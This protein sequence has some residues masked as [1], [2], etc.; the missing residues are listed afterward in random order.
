MFSI[1]LNKNR[2]RMN[3]VNSIGIVMKKRM[4][5]FL[6][7]I[8]M[9]TLG[10]S[11]TI[12]IN[13]QLFVGGTYHDSCN[14]TVPIDLNTVGSNG[15]GY[16]TATKSF[17]NNYFILVM[18]PA[19][20]AAM[21][22]TD[23][24]ASIAL[25]AGT[26]IGRYTFS[27]SQVPYT[28]F[29]NGV[30]PQ[31]GAGINA[32]NVVFKV[33]STLPFVVSDVTPVVARKRTAA[34]RLKSFAT[35]GAIGN[36][37]A[38][39]Y[40]PNHFAMFFGYCGAV[41]DSKGNP[42]DTSISLTDSTIGSI[43]QPGSYDSVI[44][45]NNS[46]HS[47]IN[48]DTVVYRAKL[49]ATKGIINFPSSILKAG[50]Y[51]TLLLKALDDSGYTSSK[52]YFILNTGWVLN[53]QKS[54]S[55][56]GC[57]GDTVNL[58]P[59]IN[60][61]QLGHQFGI[62]DNFPGLL[63]NVNWGDPKKPGTTNFSYS[64][65]MNNGGILSHVY[66]TTSCLNASKSWPITAKLTN[67]FQGNSCSYPVATPTIQIFA[68]VKAKFIHHQ[69]VCAFN[70]LDTAS[71]TLVDS[72]YAGSNTTCTGT[73][74]YTWYRTFVGCGT[75]ND[76][77]TNPFVAVDSS[78]TIISGNPVMQSVSHW[79]HKDVFSQP[80]KYIFELFADN[81]SCKTDG[82]IDS[83]MVVAPPKA[84]FLFDSLGNKVSSI[85][86]C[87]PLT[88]SVNNLSDSTCS[89]KWSFKWEVLDSLNG[90]VV[91]IPGAGSAYTF[92]GSSKNTDSAPSLVFNIQG[93]YKV[94]L[95]GSNA[96]TKADTAYRVVKVIGNGG[97]TFPTGNK[98]KIG[99][100][101]INAFCIYQGASKTVNFD[102]TVKT[103]AI[104]LVLKPTFGGT[105][106]TVTPFTWTI[107]DISGIHTYNG[108][109]SSSS[110]FPNV[111]F[112]PPANQDGAYLVKVEY[113]STC[114]VSRDS[115]MLYLNRQVIP[116]ITIPSKDTLVCPNTTSLNFTGTVT[117]ANGTNS[118]YSSTSWTDLSTNTIFANGLNA[119]LNSISTKTIKFMAYKTQPNG[120]PDTFV[121]RKI[122]LL[123][124][125]TGRD[126]GFRNC[127][128][129]QLNY[130]PA[131]TSTT[132]GNTFTW[133]S[134]VI[135]SAVVSGNTNCNGPCGNIKDILTGDGNQDVVIYTV[136]PISANGCPGNTFQVADTILPY[137]IITLK[138]ASFKD[139]ICSGAKTHLYVGSS[140]SGTI[141]NWS[142]TVFS[143]NNLTPV[144][145]WPS[146]T[147]Q[148]PTS[149]PGPYLDIAFTN[150]DNTLD[151]FKVVATVSIAGSCSSKPDSV[152]MYVIP[153][154]TQPKAN[155]P[156]DSI[157]LC[158]LSSVNLNAT[159]PP[160]SK[161]EIGIW[162]QTNGA[163]PVAAISN[164]SSPTATAF[165]APGNVYQLTWSI[166]SP[167]AATYGCP[168]LSDV[169][170][171]F[172]RP[173]VT[174]ANAGKDTTICSY[175]GNNVTINLNGNVDITRPWE[176]GTWTAS[177]TPPAVADNF[178]STGI[179]TSHKYND[180]YIFRGAT[181]EYDLV[182]TISND[183]GCPVSFDT[184]KI[185]AGFGNNTISKDTSICV[186]QSVAPLFNGSL[187]TGGGGS[188]V[189][190]WYSG[191]LIPGA[192]SQNY[193][194]IPSPA[195]TTT[196]YRT[197]SSVNCPTANLKSNFATITVYQLPK[198]GLIVTKKT[199]CGA[200]SSYQGFVLDS[201]I[202]RIDTVNYPIDTTCVYSWYVNGVLKYTGPFY[203]KSGLYTIANPGDS[204]IV[205]LRDSSKHGCGTVVSI[206]DTFYTRIKPQPLFSASTYASCNA[207][208]VTFT[209]T[210][211]NPALYAGWSWN[212]GDGA[213]PQ[214]STTANTYNPPGQI[215]YAASKIGRDSVYNICLSAWTACLDTVTLCK[216]VTIM[217]KPNPSFYMSKYSGCAP[218]Y[219]TL[220]NTTL[221][222][223]DSAR[224]YWYYPQT[225]SNYTT[226]YNSNPVP[227]VFPFSAGVML[228][229][230]NQCGEDS[231]KIVN[232]QVAYTAVNLKLGITPNHKYACAP[233]ISDV[234]Y[235]AVGADKVDFWYYPY[236][237]GT[238]NLIPDH[239]DYVTAGIYSINF[240][241]AG[242]YVVKVKASNI[243]DSVVKYDTVTMF[244]TP[245]PQFKLLKDTICVGDTVR[246]V[247]LTAT[248]GV[249]YYWKFSTQGI[250]L[251]NPPT[252]GIAN[253]WTVFTNP[254]SDSIALAATIS[255][256]F[257]SPGYCA[258]TTKLP[259]TVVTTQKANFAVSNTHPTC[260]PATVTFTNN[261]PSSATPPT[262]WYFN[263]PSLTPTVSGTNNTFYT[264]QDTGTY[265][266]VLNTMSAGGCKYTDTQ[267]IVVTS[268]YAQVWK[269]DHGFIC[270]ATPVKFQVMNPSGVDSIFVWHFG[271]G[272]TATTP[273][274]APNT[275]HSY[276]NCGNYFPTVDL[277]S[278]GGCKFT[279]N[280][281]TGDTIKVDYVKAD[282]TYAINKNC[283]NTNI[284]FT[285]ISSSCSGFNANSWSW[286][287]GDIGLP[288][289]FSTL[290]N[291]CHAYHTTDTDSILLQVTANS[292]CTNTTLVPI[293]IKVNSIPQ[294]TTHVINPYNGVVA[295][296]GQTVS[297]SGT[298][299][300]ID[301][302][303]D[304]VWTFG[305]FG[306]TA[307]GTKT[308]NTYAATGTYLDTFTV[309]TIFGCTA[310]FFGTVNVL[311]T[312]TI[313]IAQTNPP[314]ICRGQ[315]YP[316]NATT[317]DP[318]T[319][320][321]LW[322]PAP[323]VTCVNA[324]CS[325]VTVNPTTNSVLYVQGLASNG[326]TGYGDT[327]LLKVIQPITLTVSPSNDTICIG[328]SVQLH[329]VSIG[330]TAFVWDAK[331]SSLNFDSIPD[332]IA[333][334]KHIGMNVY[335]L[336]ASNT[337]FKD[338]VQVHIAVGGY[339]VISLGAPGY[340]TLT[341]QTGSTLPMFNYV[342][343]SN[344]TFKTFVWTPSTGL[345][346]NNC[347][348]PV[349]TVAGNELY[350]L[351][352]T[353]I[354]GCSDT[355]YL[356]IKT[357]CQNSQVYI[358]NAFTPDGDGRNDVLM[359]R[360]SGI[361]LVKNFR[362][363]NRWGQVVFERANFN[364]NDPQFGWDGKVRNTSTFSPPD[365]YVYYCEVVCDDD[366]PFTYQGNIT[367]IK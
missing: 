46:F 65:L 285:D 250:T 340:D 162:S 298:A 116:K 45:I 129:V 223:F 122:T 263:Y 363:Y 132:A 257:P 21:S 24:S 125:V 295:C 12:T 29:V 145:T 120:C 326:C 163:L 159:V 49:N 113:S 180:G 244:L 187:P 283:G 206:K 61:I 7:G 312:P 241:T 276:I 191:S 158:N 321:F 306:Q 262:V 219:D 157:Y 287:F 247:N 194:P 56:N 300:S 189:Y 27:G 212:F 47:L 182:W 139:T 58:Y 146:Q 282:F 352:A 355:D 165:V 334:P 246:P 204:A 325:N 127:S 97:V 225:P 134:S 109:T 235:N 62:Y 64:Q 349:V 78:A 361:K 152:V 238:P 184:L 236:P 154:P 242:Q 239:T 314:E 284:C 311:Q 359:V 293:Y 335:T 215:C 170:T 166:T 5:C 286:N 229:V 329:G 164:L 222:H 316:L 66:D 143:G 296:T 254:G 337:C 32:D 16:D 208:C 88:V 79:N 367:L 81:K 96:C 221:G 57:K 353:T 303:K 26:K 117:A 35:V 332:P 28:T 151:S 313:A 95:I 167:L 6:V 43:T 319:T 104:D 231:T 237:G 15:F 288:A 74:F 144:G 128:G 366:I 351:K 110:A 289:N 20:N 234:I 131:L 150:G 230:Y 274:N 179:D 141:Y 211:L 356:Y 249:S 140:L 186:G 76:T 240:P 364:V 55:P 193:T 209:D 278:K 258:D 345:N 87:S 85:S 161:G 34:P 256:P 105:A 48:T 346:C 269:Y 111:T 176:V 69:P 248:P 90:N 94:R 304:Y 11:Q 264:Y 59:L 99:G 123:P 301:P 18:L 133:V 9:L 175:A 80:G 44:L 52:S 135:G 203:P 270:G 190:Q 331:D 178:I 280:W 39:N 297:Y 53:L 148:T 197:T 272:T 91:I 317:N 347:P 98:G 185:G 216:T 108:L 200:T 137:P 253:P 310:Q 83:I 294:I 14:I 309:S 336:R 67:P 226:V 114:G 233:H 136:T 119:T 201:S 72:S 115:F 169:V 324:N 333:T 305:A 100:V 42:A 210:T 172:D 149:N 155:T 273:W 106:N 199:D 365:V 51:Y 19:A 279:L 196:Y 213:T 160:A 202:I 73:A 177:N 82:Y 268:P 267:K 318:G 192:T 308:V 339:P 4:I 22:L 261:S 341:V 232:L 198:T 93:V 214:S 138:D 60:S 1:S 37:T 292:G 102:T 224:I 75:I 13:Q 71:V 183:A 118:G 101:N 30:I 260:I 299:T 50:E 220:Y 2:N 328:Q 291:P 342:H 252:S 171:I 142:S 31:L 130:N 265:N 243:C 207:T 40:D 121:T 124:A 17:K 70:A 217:A 3:F 112:T 275:T 38:I 290:Q 327:V 271:D 259:Y 156:K 362:I 173:S 227:Q 36:T 251:P 168:A 358:P 343:L 103:P 245:F 181:G 344:D 281:N 126:T 255:Y 323:I 68:S 277:I 354:Y 218:L 315:V 302:I 84:N 330:A 266:V 77:T 322:G 89:Q 33:I 25:A 8:L 54:V 23:T 107:T 320:T 174:T 86:G 205:E 10:H 41:L 338:S 63:Y 92:A 153:G 360:G 188:Y 348:D 350:T 357:F 307:T 147:N 228:R 195:V